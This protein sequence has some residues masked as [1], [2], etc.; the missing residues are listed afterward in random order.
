[1]TATITDYIPHKR[2]VVLEAWADGGKQRMLLLRFSSKAFRRLY[3]AER[4]V[5]IGRRIEAE[6]D[7]TEVTFLD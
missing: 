7:G 5:L 2:T 1:M 3:M 6:P 4:G